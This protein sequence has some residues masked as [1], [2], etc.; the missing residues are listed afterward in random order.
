MKDVADLTDEQLAIVHEIENRTITVGGTDTG[1]VRPT[2]RVTN[3]KLYD[4]LKALVQKGR[5]LGL[6]KE[7]QTHEAGKSFEEWLD[8]VRAHAEKRK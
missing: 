8:K 2:V 1:T 7:T 5:R 3:L 6:F 4:K